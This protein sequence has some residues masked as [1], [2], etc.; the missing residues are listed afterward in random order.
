M[1]QTTERTTKQTIPPHAAAT[2]TVRETTGVG[3]KSN[4]AVWLIGGIV[5]VA[6]I[7]A[8]ILLAPPDR[9]AVAPTAPQVDNNVTVTPPAVP[10]VT[11]P[12]QPVEP[13]PAQP[14]TPP[15]AEPAPAQPATPP[16]AQ[17][18]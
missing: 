4:A 15:A 17:S 11:P 10:P 2:H 18:Q 6:A 9:T 13:A 14:G 1:A 3:E 16:A 7:V 12:A 5:V 8:F